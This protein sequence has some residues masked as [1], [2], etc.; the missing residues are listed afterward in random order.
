MIE[1]TYEETMTRL[2]REIA[3]LKG[4]VEG[5]REIVDILSGTKRSEII[6]EL[7]NKFK[8]IDKGIKLK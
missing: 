3:Y 1:E 5:Y 7:T 4:Q 8:E 2:K 6:K